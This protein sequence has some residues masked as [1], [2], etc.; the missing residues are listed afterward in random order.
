[1]IFFMPGDLAMAGRPSISVTE[2]P[3]I[4]RGVSEPGPAAPGVL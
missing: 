2:G 3:T 4:C 1:M